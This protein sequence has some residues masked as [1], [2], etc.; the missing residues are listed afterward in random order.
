MELAVFI[1]KNTDTAVARLLGVS[2]RT[3]ASWRRLERTPNPLLSLKIIELSH[4]EVDWKG[5]YQP[6]A[7]YRRRK[8]RKASSNPSI[9]TL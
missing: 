8:Q 3:V 2:E 4:G 7:Q 9:N 5:I 1:K 6:F